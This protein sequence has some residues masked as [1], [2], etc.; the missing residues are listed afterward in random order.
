MSDVVL[1]EFAILQSTVIVYVFTLK[2]AVHVSC[3]FDR[4]MLRYLVAK[5]MC[6]RYIVLHCT[7]IIYMIEFKTTLD[8]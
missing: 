5:L 7:Y 2:G 6:L 1:L 4:P 8:Y 3:L